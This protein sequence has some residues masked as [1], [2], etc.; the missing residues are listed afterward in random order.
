MVLVEIKKGSFKVLSENSSLSELSDV[1]TEL[2]TV[3]EDKEIFFVNEY[4]SSNTILVRDF[5][6]KDKGFYS[7]LIICDDI[8]QLTSLAQLVEYLPRVVN[9]SQE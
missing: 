2:T 5:A 7:S 9:S 6:T 8:K 3:Y 1:L 4:K